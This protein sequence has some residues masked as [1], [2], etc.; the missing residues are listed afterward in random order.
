MLSALLKGELALGI[1]SQHVRGAICQ[2]A[3]LL[4]GRFI[5]IVNVTAADDDIGAIVLTA[6]AGGSASP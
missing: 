4:S 5:V 2:A 3:L 1:A 6:A